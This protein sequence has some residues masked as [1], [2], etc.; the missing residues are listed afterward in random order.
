MRDETSETRL[1]IVE[2][3]ATIDKRE[4]DAPPPIRSLRRARDG[5]P[6]GLTI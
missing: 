2:E 3:R 1:P 5:R 4:V 6:S